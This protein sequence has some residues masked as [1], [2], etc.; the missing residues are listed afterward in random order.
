MLIWA[1]GYI[2]GDQQ[3]VLVPLLS[4][5]KICLLASFTHRYGFKWWEKNR[6]EKH[7]VSLL[8]PSP[9]PNHTHMEGIGSHSQRT[10][11]PYLYSFSQSTKVRQKN[12]EE[13]TAVLPHPQPIPDIYSYLFYLDQA[14]N[15]GF[16]PHW[17][18]KTEKKKNPSPIS[19]A[20]CFQ[21]ALR[22][23]AFGLNPHLLC[24]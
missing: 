10:L 24:F 14:G 22:Q 6:N 13:V 11:R 18:K 8:L 12:N 19:P 3:P 21:V 1:Q 20:S 17:G 7:N 16:W 2:P 4:L 15:I 5:T 23:P 9:T